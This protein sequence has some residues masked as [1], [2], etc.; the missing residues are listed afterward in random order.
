[1]QTELT[2]TFLI[3]F[4]TCP[5]QTSYWWAVPILPWHWRSAMPVGYPVSW[6]WASRPAEREWTFHGSSWLCMGCCSSGGCE[7]DGGRQDSDDSSWKVDRWANIS[8]MHARDKNAGINWQIILKFLQLSLLE[9]LYMTCTDASRC[10]TD[11]W[12]IFWGLW[13]YADM[14]MITKIIQHLKC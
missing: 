9:I 1:M 12:Y 13:P 8:I 11:I 14:P 4:S 2:V 6:N 7:E 5:T 10:I 3:N